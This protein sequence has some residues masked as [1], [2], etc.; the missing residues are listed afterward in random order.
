[1][2]PVLSRVAT[3]QGFGSI[4]SYKRV[5]LASQGGGAY[6]ISR[7][8]RFNAPDSAYLSRTPASA[9]NRKTWTFSCWIK[10]SGSGSRMD[11]L[12]TNIATS[13][14]Y[15][16]FQFSSSNAISLGYFNGEIFTTS[17][18]YRDFSAWM[19]VVLAL[20]TTLATAA[21]RVKLYVNGSRV[22]TFSTDNISSVLTQNSDQGINAVQPHSIGR[23]DNG[24]NVYFDGYLAD[25]YLIDGQQLDPSS[26]TT[27]DLNGQLQP[28]AYTGSYGTN[29]FKLFFSDNSTTA[30]LGT[31]TSVTRPTLDPRYGMDVVT[32][33]G[34]SSTQTI[35]TL[36]F[37][38]DFVWIK[39]R[40]QSN[41]AHRLYDTI[42]GP[43][44]SLASSDTGAQQ[45]VANTLSAFTSNGFLL[46]SDVSENNSGDTYVAWCWKAGGASVS[47]TAGSITSTVSANPTYG[48]SVATYT[49]GSPAGIYTVGHGLGTAPSMIFIKARTNNTGANDWFVYHKDLG[50]T[51]ALVLNSTAASSTYTY[52]NNTNPTSTVF[53]VGAGIDNGGINW[54]AYC[55]AE[56]AGFSKF[57]SY[58][59][60]GSS[61]GPTVTL[62]F[63]PRFV[64]VK[65]TD[66]SVDWVIIDSAR[67]SSD[68]RKNEL[69]PNAIAAEGTNGG[70]LAFT[71]TGFTI[72]TN[73]SSW[74]ASGGTYIYAAYA[75]SP[76][77]NWTPNNLSVAQGNGSY[78]SG[79]FSGDVRA[80]T[81]AYGPR[82]MFNGIVGNENTTGAAC[83]APYSSNS[84]CTWTSTTTITGISSLRIYAILSGTT[85]KLTVNGTDYSSLVTPLSGGG[86][87]VTIPQ[88]SLSSIA[89]GY[90]GG[91]NSATGVAAVEV[92][93]VILLD[94]FINSNIDSLVDSPTSYGTPDT[95]VGGEVRGN[96]CTL[97]PL[98]SGG[99]TVS[100]GNLEHTYN[101]SNLRVKSTISIPATDKWYAEFVASNAAGGNSLVGIAT[102]ASALTGS[103]WYLG[104]DAGSWGLQIGSGTMYT[105]HNGA[106]SSF[107]TANNGDVIGVAVDR[108]AGKIWWSV[109][110]TWIASGDPAN[111]T[112][113]RY[114]N[115]PAT[116]TLFFALSNAN[117]SSI[118][119][120]WGQ[121]AFAYTAPSGF[122]A[123]V[124]TNLPAPTI[125]L[126]NTAF[127][128]KLYTGNGGTQSITGLNFSPDLVLCKGRSFP[129]GFMWFD[130]VRGGT[131]S[132][133]SNDTLGDTGL[134]GKLSSFDSNGFTMIP[135]TDG[136][137]PSVHNQS[138]ETYAT[139][140]WD[141]GTST[142]TN[143]AGSITSQVRANPSAG[144]SVVTYTGTGSSG[145]IGHGL[146]VKPKVVLI[147]NRDAAAD[148]GFYYDFVDGTMDR[149]LLNTTDAKTDQAVSAPTS[150]VFSTAGGSG[151]GANGEKYV[152]YV[153]SSVSGYSSFGSYVA[154]SG[155]PF[156]YLGFKPA[157]VMIKA[158]VGR[159]TAYTSWYMADNKRP[160]YNPENLP[161][162]ANQ[163]A[164]EG[165]RGNGSGTYSSDLNIDLLSNGFKIRDNN[166]APDETNFT[167]ATYIY[168]AWAE[169]PF[170]Y[171]RAR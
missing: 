24:A 72:N 74:N 105:Y 132:L 62:G 55:W 119:C 69:Y 87:Y 42:R 14:N 118:V 89:F 95:G 22:T 19:H 39:S 169:S 84:T 49:S 85:G 13:G 122:K 155:E 154:G 6:Q 121:R 45:T 20:D 171:A 61:T 167:G 96:Y 77:N 81:D 160:V 60:N 34:N 3:G 117:S 141:G 48:F 66:A 142:V 102:G 63:R 71:D 8:L 104:N 108:A 139:W 80:L 152:A 47:N 135:G 136:A 16:S 82:N 110:N 25:V 100:N 79:Q 150:T 15:L 94:N 78:I 109:N 46:G 93:G 149:L 127:D 134:Y 106:V 97:N 26:F 111:G 50:N 1:M 32:Y 162:W 57:G 140:C 36:G 9:G 128:V 76:G 75:E 59:G 28:K 38:P 159:S 98:D 17:A 11:V 53:S 91:I 70:P 101:S 115:V 99:G 41:R 40:S 124:D 90:T 44:N 144:F 158:A 5:Y 138:G 12:S 163:S 157:L 166:G 165:L 2:S 151:D 130:I 131:V 148:W 133:R 88:S 120:N 123:L 145:T 52:W 170:N 73:S 10:R 35:N 7:S 4:V 164:Q 33:T 86:G 156:V 168:C 54:V 83:F 29:G 125:A 43:F 31:D 64:M 65:R 37:A 58:T 113:A 161:L 107:G 92:N 23:N 68:P 30:A 146:G 126:S 147:K 137:N 112:N 129:S 103:N 27:S 51:K 56:I 143:T 116:D 153:F 18:V 21:D 67:S 114:S